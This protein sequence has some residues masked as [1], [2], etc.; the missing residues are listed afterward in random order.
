MSARANAWYRWSSRLLGLLVCLYLG[1]FAVGTTGL[2]LVMHLV[3]AALVLAVV[4]VGWRWPAVGG[5][6]F[7]A[8]GGAYALAAWSH[9]IWIAAVSGP[10]VVVGALF[11]AS[12]SRP[13]R[14]AA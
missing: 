2:G 14:M 11:L 7:I 1:Q 3:P 10:L 5:A 13:A 9:P 12:R 6:G 8:L 4:A